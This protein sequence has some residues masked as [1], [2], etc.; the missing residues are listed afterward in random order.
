MEQKQ[1]VKQDYLNY[2]DTYVIKDRYRE[3]SV[4]RVNLQDGSPVLMCLRSEYIQTS[5]GGYCYDYFKVYTPFNVVK[6]ELAQLGFNIST[7]A[8]FIEDSEATLTSERSHILTQMLDAP[9]NINMAEINV[10]RNYVAK[11]V[12]GK[13]KDSKDIYHLDCLKDTLARKDRYLTRVNLYYNDDAQKLE[14]IIY[15]STNGDDIG[16]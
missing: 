6:V 15:G 12:D 14:E 9:S 16:I 5:A 7:A 2:V 11:C 3:I 1:E 4:K 10:W 13:F 8:A